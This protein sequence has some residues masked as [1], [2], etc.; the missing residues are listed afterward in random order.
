[1][2]RAPWIAA[3][4]LAAGA[5]AWIGVRACGPDVTVARFDALSAP[6]TALKDFVAGRLGILRPGF[7][8]R[9][10]VV[11]YRWL[12]GLGISPADQAALVAAPPDPWTSPDPKRWLRAR[13]LAMKD[14]APEIQPMSQGDSWSQYAR[15][16]QGALD[17]ASATLTDRMGRYGDGPD[18]KAW[19]A[20]QD[21]VFASTKE[22]PAIPS[23]IA[24]PAWLKA[25]RDYQI[26]AARL[27]AERFDEAA[28]AFKAI[29]QDP[30]SPWRAWAPYL[31]ARCLVRKVSLAPDLAQ[32]APPEALAAR[33][34]Q[35][36]AVQ[37]LIEADLP[38]ADPRV[39]AALRSLRDLVRHRSEPGALWAEDLQML[40]TEKDGIAP[41]VD[42]A[43]WVILQGHND[44]SDAPG[45]GADLQAWLDVMDVNDGMKAGRPGLAFDQWKATGSKAWLVAAMALCPGPGPEAEELAAAAAKV[46]ESDPAAPTL[47]W[48]ALQTRLASLD[49]GP[50]RA[51]LEAALK[52]PFPIWAKNSLLRQCGALATDLDDWMRAAVHEV[53]GYGDGMSDEVTSP[54]P[55]DNA[56]LP[57]RLF[58]HDEAATLNRAFTVAQLANAAKTPGL[59]PALRDEILRVAWL[60]ATLMDRWDQAAALAPSLE[61]ALK[62]QAMEV[63]AIQ[64]PES[65]RFALARLVMA[66]PGLRPTINEGLGGFRLGEKLSDFDAIRDNWWCGDGV[67]WLVDGA[68]QPIPAPAP[69]AF[70]TAEE[71]KVAAEEQAILAKVP[72][73]IEWFGRITLDHAKAHPEDPAVPDTLARVVALTRSPM[74]ESKAISTLSRDAFRVLHTA[75]KDTAAAKR[76]KYHY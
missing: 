47:R 41:L 46:P 63:C 69:P 28:A 73:A 31:E 64:D 42:S 55:G 3:A 72:S 13:S 44:G 74:C 7:R 61:S 24:A 52:Q 2:R 62:T 60:R 58:D 34:Q 25:D 9:D 5:A 12:S 75:Y 76:T 65:R 17:T 67:Y 1:M 15:L 48:Y 4:V 50:K 22:H 70:L 66:F 30:A 18:L 20:G 39:D 16:T 54:G 27:Y 35:W 21:L 33:V 8:F 32:D 29:A 49:G 23:P 71:T 43:R 19:V 36:R 45:A 37:S 6:D 40:A 38:A 68:G 53:V 56:S 14:Q 51:A 59:P 26:A 57:T 10:R 11:A